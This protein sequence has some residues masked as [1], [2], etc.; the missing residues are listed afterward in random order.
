MMGVSLIVAIGAQ[1]I[2]VLSQSMTNPHRL[3]IALVCIICD[4]LLIILG[5]YAA[6]E[7][8]NIIPQILPLLTWG[9]IAMLLYLAYQAL[10]RVIK[11]KSH[12]SITDVNPMTRQ[13]TVI[14]ALGISLLN[15]H[16][17]L[18]TVVLLGSIGS[19]QASPLLFAV[20]ACIAS[21]CWFSSITFFAPNLRCWLHSSFRWRMF[22][23][24]IA[25]FLCT[26]AYKL[27]NFA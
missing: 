18:D 19:M 2:W 5:V 9:G 1:N 15:P 14:T 7:I 21:V 13:A 6:S 4:M 24:L 22:D 11:G 26:V 23:S 8:G 16:V 12:L 27:I 10:V 17:Y 20:G 25:I 3:F